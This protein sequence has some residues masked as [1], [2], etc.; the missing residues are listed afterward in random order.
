M[1]D[2]ENALGKYLPSVGLSKRQKDHLGDDAY[3]MF[4]MCVFMNKQV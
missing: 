4:V 1:Y 3:E 2:C